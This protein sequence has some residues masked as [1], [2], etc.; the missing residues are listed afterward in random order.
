V[1]KSSDAR[2]GERTPCDAAAA[3]AAAPVI[4]YATLV[5]TNQRDILLR[6]WFWLQFRY[7]FL[8]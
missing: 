6:C 1:L 8:S 5:S 7:V 3:A 2:D 4:S